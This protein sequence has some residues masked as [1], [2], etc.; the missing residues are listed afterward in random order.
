MS[1]VARALTI[2]AKKD[3]HCLSW[4]QTHYR[5]FDGVHLDFT[6]KCS[7]ALAKDC[8]PGS[9]QFAI[10]VQN[11]KTCDNRKSSAC[12]RAVLMY[13]GEKVYKVATG[14]RVTVDD[15][16]V[17][18]PYKDSSVSI[19]K[20]LSYVIMRAWGDDLE[21]K[22]D[23]VSGVYVGLASKY[24]NTTCGLCGNYNGVPEDDLFK[25]NTNQKASS[26]AVLAD[27]WAMPD[28]KETCPPAGLVNMNVCKNVSSSASQ[29]AKRMCMVL[30]G[31]NFGACHSKVD[32][33]SFVERCE[34][35]VCM[36]NFGQHSGCQCEALTQYSRACANKGVTLNWRSKYLCRKYD[37]VG[38]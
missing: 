14:N 18:L 9:D 22:F 15:K 25:A 31:E 11:D 1:V 3:G 35:D 29:S 38:I 16:K 36:C 20:I 12:T 13:V 34:L 27:S 24:K 2:S 23:G 21:V 26:V 7:Y 5:T 33:K 28:P 19:S 37:V 6:G 32:P 30:L 4:G 8:I 17:F 10:H